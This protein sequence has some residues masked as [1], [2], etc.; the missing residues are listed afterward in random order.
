MIDIR[1]IGKSLFLLYALAKALKQKRSVI[2]C[3]NDSEFLVFDENGV[4][5]RNM[6]HYVIYPTGP[7]VLVLCDCNPDL[8]SPPACFVNPMSISQACIVQAAQIQTYC[9]KEWSKQ[10]TA[11]IWPMQLWSSEEMK[12]LWYVGVHNVL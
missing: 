6:I 8:P 4:Q 3:T 1:A 12:D 9:W 2:Y 7:D 10:M 5:W 11:R